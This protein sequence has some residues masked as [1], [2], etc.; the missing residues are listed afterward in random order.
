MKYFIL[1]LLLLTCLTQSVFAQVDTDEFIIRVNVDADI[2]A[3]TTPTLLSAMPVATSQVDIAWSSS[4]DNVVVSGY[5]VLRD[6]VPIATTS[7]LSYSDTGL[8]AGTTYTYT[9]QAFDI[10]YNYSSTSNSLS[11]E[12][13]ASPESERE[14]GTV[15]RVV[16]DGLTIETGVSTTSFALQTAH[17]A[18]LELRWGR[19]ASYELGYVVSN[20][21][22]KE[23]SV[24][25][26]DLE[27]GT[28]YEY[29]IVGY[30]PFGAQTIL[31]KGTFT[32]LGVLQ[33]VSLPNVSR[34][35]A[36]G[37]GDDV[38]LSWLVPESEN[39]SHVRV[40]R[41][42]FGFPEHP[43]DGAVVYQGLKGIAR[44][45]KIL[46]QYSPV[47]YTAFVYDVYGNVSS[48][49][50]AMV[51]ATRPAGETTAPSDNGFQ[52]K[53]DPVTNIGDTMVPTDESTST[54]HVERFTVDMKMPKLSDIVIIQEDRRFTFIDPDIILNPE[55]DFIL[56][57]PKGAVAGNLKSIIATVV[58]PTD[59]RQTYSYLL[60]INK[61]LTAYEAQIAPF[62]VNGESQV[63]LEIY[64]YEA[65]VIGTYQAPLTFTKPSQEVEEAVVFPDVLFQYWP[66]VVVTALVVI[67]LLL[68]FFLVRRR[69][70]DNE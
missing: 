23:H 37:I 19:T 57:L 56:S 47:Y 63:V 14:G 25:L 15:A 29:E 52:N 11:V 27:P 61:N 34:F 39:I 67:S 62:S 18:R 28:T 48:G 33:Q 43:Q 32:T 53:P 46:A 70:E 22:T 1:V 21:F 17:Q 66:H 50:V 36:V 12:T 8:F 35:R 10:S 64:D 40:V 42:H 24:L 9:V 41:S 65:F 59:N 49:A 20:I 51:Y 13:F 31:K 5:S 69:G 7:L 26:T 16:L 3:P 58:D 55:K 4:T 68:V 44:D 6:G 60:R 2:A 45:E 38:E 54:I 30:T